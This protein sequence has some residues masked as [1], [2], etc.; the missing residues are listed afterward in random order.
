MKDYWMVDALEA[1]LKSEEE[2]KGRSALVRPDMS[3]Q[4]LC[5]ERH[6]SMQN[7]RK[8]G[9]RMRHVRSGKG[10]PS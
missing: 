1:Q 4:K 10:L 8:A 3:T 7:L 2:V 9:S 6:S 5:G